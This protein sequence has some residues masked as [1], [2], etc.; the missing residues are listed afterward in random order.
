MMS[1]CFSLISSFSLSISL[2]FPPSISLSFPP[3]ISLSFSPFPF[4]EGLGVGFLLFLPSLWGGAGGRLFF[5]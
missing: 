2:S 1:F 3:S 4:R 5:H